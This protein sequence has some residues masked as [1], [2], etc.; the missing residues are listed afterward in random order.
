M[1]D[2]RLLEPTL[3]VPETLRPR[4][5]VS[6]PGLNRETLDELGRLGWARVGL[7]VAVIDP[8]GGIMMLEHNR[9]AKN[10]ADTLGP[11]GETSQEAGP[12]IEQPV[13]TLFRGFREELVVKRPE[14]LE[15]WIRSEA[16]WVINQW[17]R[18]DA[19][20]GEFACAI[21]FPIFISDS[22]RAYLESIPRGTEEIKR[23]YG[24]MPAESIQAQPD[25][26]LRPGVKDWLGQLAA[27]NLL[28]PGDNEGLVRVD[29]SSVYEASLRDIELSGS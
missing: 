29:F 28:D 5:G 13:G 1:L 18:G 3:P 6:L 23:L 22:V 9:R 27:A 7:M 19:H 12:V 15:L 11:L 21:S 20:P 26:R 25:E 10:A 8:S 4:S 16:G 2:P 24:F 14:D 17:P